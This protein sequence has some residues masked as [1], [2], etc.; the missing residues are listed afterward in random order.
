MHG[1]SW[2]CM[3]MC[4]Y[5]WMRMDMHGCAWISMD[6]V[7]NCFGNMFVRF[8]SFVGSASLS[9]FLSN[10]SNLELEAAISTVLQHFRAQN[11]HVTRAK[12]HEGTCIFNPT[13]RR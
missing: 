4:G 1:Q 10:C 3:D 13:E 5:V 12:H 2:I 7:R 8:V 6:G 9:I 11:V